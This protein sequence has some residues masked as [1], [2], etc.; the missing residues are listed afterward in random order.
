MINTDK[1]L[2]VKY[3]NEMYVRLLERGFRDRDFI[4][5]IEGMIFCVIGNVHPKNSV[6]AYLKYVPYAESSIRVKW[7]RDGVMYGRVLPFYSAIGV[8]SVIEYLKRNYPH[9]VVYDEYRNI[10]LI[11]VEKRWIK[12]HYRPEERLN[13]ILNEPKDSLEQMAKELVTKLSEESGVS[14]KYFGITGSIL[15][16][17][18]NPSISDIDI[19]VYGKENSYRV[20][21][22]LLRLYANTVSS[23]FSLPQGDI[24]MEWARDIVK[25]HPLNLDEA[26]LLYGK[27]KWNR[28]LYMGRQ[29]SIH[30]VKLENEVNE[31]W[32]QK[33]YRPMGIATIKAKVVDSSDSIFMP[34][35]Y[36]VDDVEVIEGN[37]EA[38]KVSKVVSYEGLYIDLATPGEDV[39]VRGKLEEVIDLKT[40]EKHYQITV[41]TY[42]AGGKDYIKPVKWFKHK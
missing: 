33:R 32:E 11:E 25:I 40:S 29:F 38:I 31:E 9:Y 17:I 4:E 5:T 22:A 41:G 19:V 23:N 39:I 30:P 3:D 13:E 14:L 37:E 1:V 16:N 36:N 34:A 24:L 15:L 42:E 12:K 26:L 8:Q 6:V 2:I 7:S 20:K 27:F 21:E 10:E 28:A 18:H 35:I